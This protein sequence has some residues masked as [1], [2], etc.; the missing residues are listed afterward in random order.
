MRAEIEAHVSRASDHDSAQG[1]SAVA[2][3]WDAL[4][5][6]YDAAHA[7][8]F[9]AECALRD[10]DRERAGRVLAD[11]HATATRLG[12]EPLRR[13]CEATAR[14]GN[15][16][17]V[18]TSSAA[19]GGLTPREVEVLG[20]VALGRT[21]GEVAATLFIS[22]KTVSVHISNILAKLGAANRTEAAA[23]ARNQGLIDV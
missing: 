19:A 14:R 17:R 8:V 9:E 12:A 10:G 5:R 1:W 20:H 7:S 4:A 3:R 16:H 13:R 2:Q 18:G 11:A 22:T 23:L 15:L 6:P 21:N